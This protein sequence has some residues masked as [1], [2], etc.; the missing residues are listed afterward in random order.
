MVF[1]PIQKYAERQGI[2]YGTTRQ[3]RP[4]R[5][6]LAYAPHGIRTRRAPINWKG[7][8]PQTNRFPQSYLLST[9]HEINQ[10]MKAPSPNMITRSASQK[11]VFSRPACTKTSSMEEHNIRMLLDDVHRIHKNRVIKRDALIEVQ[12]HFSTTWN[13]YIHGPS[14]T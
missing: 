2:S 11:S 3:P 13:N 6:F 8:Y 10:N 14:C 12:S 5:G 4:Q 1:R 7:I 9:H